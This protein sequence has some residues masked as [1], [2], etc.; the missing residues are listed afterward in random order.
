MDFEEIEKRVKLD[1]HSDNIVYILAI[2]PLE[3]VRSHAPELFRYVSDDV[4]K[5]MVTQNKTAL[6][7][8]VLENYFT[9]KTEDKNDLMNLITYKIIVAGALCLKARG[10]TSDDLKQLLLKGKDVEK[11]EL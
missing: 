8:S 7:W 3:H 6:I 10:Y 5:R 11:N 1:I 9:Y 4:L 2:T